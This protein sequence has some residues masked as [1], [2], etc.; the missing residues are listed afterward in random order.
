MNTR[1][2]ASMIKYDL[3]GI[4]D[5]E[6][7]INGKYIDNEEESERVRKWV[8]DE[9]QNIKK[10]HYCSSLLVTTNYEYKS[11]TEDREQNS[12]LWFCNNCA[13]WQCSFDFYSELQVTSSA[14]WFAF[15]SKAREFDTNLPEICNSELAQAIRRNQRIWNTM[16]PYKLEKLVADIFKA[17][18][19]NSEVM[20]VGKPDDGGVDV[21]FIDSGKRQWLIQVKRRENPKASEGVIVVRNLLG[22]MVIHGVLQGIL[23][24]TAD[25]FTTRAFEACGKANNNFGME[26]KLI[27]RGKLDRMLNPFIP[28]NPWF[29]A[30]SNSEYFLPEIV[31]YFSEH[32]PRKDPGQ[33]G[34][35]D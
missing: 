20:H 25:H 8:L 13:Y 23:V 9:F 33:Q 16:N 21:L 12:I 5:Y 29:E 32:L 22:T 31:E 26:L 17:N 2:P 3:L 19:E 1:P 34:L 11:E 27:D 18:Y 35:F 28:A 30:L 24:S 14:G 10:C 6:C 7:L 4:E 15:T